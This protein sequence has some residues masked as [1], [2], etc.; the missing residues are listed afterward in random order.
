LHEADDIA[1]CISYGGN[2]LAPA[3]IFDFLLDVNAH[4]Y[5]SG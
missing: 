5:Q 2:Q 4:I 3:N 1:I